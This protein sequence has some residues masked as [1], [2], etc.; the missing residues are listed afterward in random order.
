MDERQRE[1][2]RNISETGKAPAANEASEKTV[3]QT[4]Y[5]APYGHVV[6]AR[7]ILTEQ[8]QGEAVDPTPPNREG[9]RHEKQQASG[10]GPERQAQG[11]PVELRE[12][13]GQH[14]LQ[15]LRHVLSL[16]LRDRVAALF[17]VLLVSVNAP[18]IVLLSEDKVA[19]GQHP[20]E[21]SMVLIIIPVQ[22]IAPDRLEVFQAIGKPPH[23]SQV[24]TVARVVYGVGLRHAED[25]AILYMSIA[26]QADAVDLTLAELD[27]IGIRHGPECI[28]LSAEV[29]QP[30]AALGQIRHHVGAPVLEVLDPADLHHGI[31]NVDP[32]VRKQVRL[33]NDQAH[34]QK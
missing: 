9:E 28:P 1:K 25:A 21:H 29:L 5:T 23:Y 22:P 15:H 31:M 6:V 32:R 34:S 7:E 16:A 19:D 8:L 18:Y 26:R 27:Q 4:K 13:Q 33:V 30:H 14:L 10:C 17:V 20:G 3:D 2:Q 12:R 11:Y 24:F